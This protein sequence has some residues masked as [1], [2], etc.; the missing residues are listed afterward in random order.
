M[1]KLQVER[2]YERPLEDAIGKTALRG[3]QIILP[4]VAHAKGF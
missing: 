1:E 3:A 2:S 4:G